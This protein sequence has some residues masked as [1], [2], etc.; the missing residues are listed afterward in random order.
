MAL[1][2]KAHEI[3]GW[4]IVAFILAVVG[5]SFGFLFAVWP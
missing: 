1:A 5:A 2:M 4:S 3:I